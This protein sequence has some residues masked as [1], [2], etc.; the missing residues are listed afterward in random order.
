MKRISRTINPYEEFVRYVTAEVIN[1]TKM[2]E[3]IAP[4]ILPIPPTIVIII[5]VRIRF[6]PNA[7]LMNENAP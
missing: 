6:Q 1:P 4:F 2:L 7:E 3:M 5:T